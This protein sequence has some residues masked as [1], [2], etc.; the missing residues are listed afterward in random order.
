MTW[1]GDQFC[2]WQLISRSRRCKH[3]HVTKPAAAAGVQAACTNHSSI[4]L[5][6]LH[7][8]PW[9][10]RPSIP[11]PRSTPMTACHYRQS[12]TDL[13]DATST[14]LADA[15]FKLPPQ[16]RGAEPTNSHSVCITRFLSSKVFQ[17]QPL[18][19]AYNDIPCCCSCCC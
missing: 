17:G 12:D 13:A 10:R 6:A 3:C 14:V 5:S 19:S 16:P 9:G 15:G 4:Y 11:L 2:N 7:L 18:K 8:L 1:P